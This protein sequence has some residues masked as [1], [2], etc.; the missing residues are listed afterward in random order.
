MAER[1]YIFRLAISGALMKE[2]NEDFKKF[3][4]S[5]TEETDKIKPVRVLKPEDLANIGLGR[6]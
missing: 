4:K 1:A 5:M 2:G 3:M 6:K